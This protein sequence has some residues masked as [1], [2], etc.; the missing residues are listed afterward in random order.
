MSTKPK[1]IGQRDQLISIQQPVVTTNA[2]GGETVVW[3]NLATNRWAAVDYAAESR[4][5][6]LGEEV[7]QV[8]ASRRMLFT[9]QYDPSLTLNEKMRVLHDGQ[10]C[11]I[12]AIRK[13]GRNH[14]WEIEAEKRENEP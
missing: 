4:E 8:V 10:P 7:M 12:L 9:L 13:I 5:G 11:D 3:Q 6:F 1:A 2:S 14:L